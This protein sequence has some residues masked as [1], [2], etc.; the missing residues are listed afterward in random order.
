MYCYRVVLLVCLS[1]FLVSVE[2][3]SAQLIRRYG[4]NSY[5]T[6][7]G[8]LDRLWYDADRMREREIAGNQARNNPYLAAQRGYAY[9]GGLRYLPAGARA[10]YQTFLYQFGGVPINPVFPPWGR[11]YDVPRAMLGV[12]FYS[13]YRSPLY[14]Y[15]WRFGRQPYPQELGLSPE[16][17]SQRRV[18]PERDLRLDMIEAE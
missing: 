2:S 13:I 12:G 16:L 17:P 5:G 9:D 1:V 6:R 3:L 8:T 4:P 11:F 10:R 14:T 15:V 7:G 18:Y